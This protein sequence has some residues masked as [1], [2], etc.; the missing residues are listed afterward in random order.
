ME[1]E[2]D[3]LYSEFKS[4]SVDANE[5]LIQ[6]RQQNKAVSEHLTAVMDEYYRVTKLSG[7]AG[8]VIDKL[9]K[10]FQEKTKLRGWEI[11]LLFTCVALQCVR[12]YLLP[13]DKGRI[14]ATQGDTLMES[15]IDRFVKPEWRDVLLQS[16]PYDAIKTGLHVSDT[17]IAGTTH[18]YR[19][20]GHDPVLGWIFGT[21]NIMTNSLT[22]YNLET[23]QVK[24]MTIIRHYPL[25][26]FG[27]IS[28]AGMYSVNDPKLLVASLGRQIIHF[29]SD[30]FTKQG[31]PVPMIS[32]LNN[33]LAKDMLTKW[34]ID[35]YSILRGM[36]LSAFI[37]KIVFIIHQFF[38]NEDRD[39][40]RELYEVKTRKILSYS[41]LIASG[42]NIIITAITRNGKVLDVGGLIV[43]ILRLVSDYQ[44]IHKIKQE[45][46]QNGFEKAI[47]GENYDFL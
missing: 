10:V 2:L 1:Y 38:Y 32:T 16:V 44:F 3:K 5:L 6:S 27:M 23:F 17:G 19:T 37:N 25:G 45:F 46:L 14:S 39:G 7:Q 24:D 12:Q 18:R 26:V 13:N 47:V 20:L 34:N 28:R 36:G 29:G 42:S 40:S 4:L 41:N 22:K 43:T 33:E 9:D 31:L 35:T 11:V 15:T 21:A 30:I 8:Y